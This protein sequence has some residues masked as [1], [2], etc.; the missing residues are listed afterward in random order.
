MKKKIARIWSLKTI[1]YSL[2]TRSAQDDITHPILSHRELLKGSGLA[3]TIFIL[4][5]LITL[6]HFVSQCDSCC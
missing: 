2:S 1:S 3:H 6:C 4:P 5:S